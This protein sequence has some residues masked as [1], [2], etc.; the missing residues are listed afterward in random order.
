MSDSLRPFR[1]S[2]APRCLEAAARATTWL[3]TTTGNLNIEIGC[4]VG[5][6]PIRFAA[7]NPDQRILAIER[8][9]EKFD[10]FLGR[11]QNHKLNNI[12]AAHA[13]AAELLPLILSPKS[14]DR[15]FILYPNPYPKNSQK[16]LRWAFSPFFDFIYSS[17]KPR[18]EIQFA[19]NLDFYREELEKRIPMMYQF[20]TVNSFKISKE[21]PAR[22]HFEKKYQARGQDCFHISLIK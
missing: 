8:T 9:S 4:G 13:E 19:T 7:Q 11:L 6:H 1:P 18:G 22:T 3:K 16:N 21:T 2:A 20:D 17:L 15:F 10:K 14:V 12:F 5:L